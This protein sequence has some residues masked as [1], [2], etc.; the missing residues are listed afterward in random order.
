MIDSL[1]A[2]DEDPHALFVRLLSASHRR[3]LGYLCSMLGR[4]EDAEDVLQRAS[5]TLWRRFDTFQPGTDF[6]AW[7][8]TVCFYEAKNFQRVAARSKVVFSDALLEVLAHERV[9]D[10]PAQD[11]RI[12]ALHDCLGRLD[13]PGRKLLEAAYLDRSNIGL[14]AAQ[15]G[16]APQTLYNKLNTLR[17]LLAECIEQ[18]TSEV[19]P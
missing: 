10:L 13:D 4:R 11:S 9:A 18:R 8:S 19:R 12:D 16:R 5:V 17:R 7:A 2:P 15:L 1:P 3:L 14:I 6:L